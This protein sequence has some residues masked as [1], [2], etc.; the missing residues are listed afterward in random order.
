MKNIVAILIGLLIAVGGFFALKHLFKPKKPNGLESFKDVVYMRKLHLIEYHYNDMIFLHKDNNANKRLLYLVKYPVSISAS[1]DLK[2]MKIDTIS[3]VIS[4]PSPI[5]NNPILRVESE[6]AEFKEVRDGFIISFKG[7]RKD[8]LNTFHEQLQS[9]SERIKYEAIRRGILKQSKTEA[10]KFIKDLL[11]HFV[12]ANDYSISW[13]KSDSLQVL[14]DFGN[15]FKEQIL[16]HTES[17]NLKEKI[18]DDKLLNIEELDIKTIDWQMIE[19][20][21]E[22]IPAT[23]NQ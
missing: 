7:V 9:A 21:H 22:K 20:N 2:E 14:A 3:K 16:L 5:L 13:K 23:N 15:N 8:L 1:L 18:L 11:Y 17:D 4:L 6:E 10:K 19:I 12:K